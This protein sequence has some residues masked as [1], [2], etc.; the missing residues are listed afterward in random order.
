MTH[1]QIDRMNLCLNR[2]V[3]RRIETDP[4]REGLRIALANIRRWRRRGLRSPLN[5]KWEDIILSGDWPR[6]RR[7]LVTT[8]DKAIQMQQNSPFRNVLP[9][10]LRKR[11]REKFLR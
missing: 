10:E 9:M 8:T 4:E 6:I 5:K 7:Y 11:I 1:E 3:A 2:M